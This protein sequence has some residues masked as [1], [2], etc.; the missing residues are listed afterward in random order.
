M[1]KICVMVP[2]YKVEPYL[3]RCID[4][5]L[6]QTFTDFEV[7]LIDDGSPDNCPKICDEYKEKDSRIHVIH[8]KNKGIASTRNEGINYAL[9]HTDC[10]WLTFIDSDDWVEKIY[11]EAMYD[12]CISNGTDL[13]VL[14]FR[15][16]WDYDIPPVNEYKKNVMVYD[17]RTAFNYFFFDRYEISLTY[18]WGKLY[19]RKLFSEFRYPDGKIYEDL[20]STYKILFLADKISF[21]DEIGYNYFQSTNSITRS[22]WNVKN[23][24]AF[25]YNKEVFAFFKKQKAIYAYCDYIQKLEF[26]CYLQ[27]LWLLRSDLK[28]SK[29]TLFLFAQHINLVIRLFLIF[30]K[31]RS[32]SFW[33]L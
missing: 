19:N 23:A 26:I 27:F 15:T 1:A 3:R 20:G 4:S 16:V 9:N 18:S 8:Q 6:A 21:I 33:N 13:S 31:R 10:E 29:Y 5:I 17:I 11:L 22:K 12:A 25:S 2:I 7:I 32:W 28:F 30:P 24:D 14:R